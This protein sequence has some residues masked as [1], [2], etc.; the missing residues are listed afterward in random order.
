L[1]TLRLMFARLTW[2]KSHT[3]KVPIDV[4][5]VAVGLAARRVVEWKA[6][7]VMGANAAA[8]LAKRDMIVNG[9]RFIE[10]R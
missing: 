10:R 7:R 9:T 8:E 4:L 1:S 3:L 6:R 5:H 2:L